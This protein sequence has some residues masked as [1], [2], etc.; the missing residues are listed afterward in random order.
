MEAERPVMQRPHDHGSGLEK[1][2]RCSVILGSLG[3]CG[4]SD[5]AMTIVLNL[6]ASS[7]KTDHL[8]EWKNDLFERVT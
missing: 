8:I 1:D 4:R 3:F 6:P 2:A 5:C 7:F